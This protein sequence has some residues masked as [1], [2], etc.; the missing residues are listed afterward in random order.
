V[1][2]L[3]EITAASLFRVDLKE[4]RGF[5]LFLYFTIEHMFYIINIY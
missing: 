4:R 5:A 1:S 3:R 2:N